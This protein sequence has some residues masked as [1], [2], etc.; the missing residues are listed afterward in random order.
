M[1]CRS[2]DRLDANTIKQNNKHAYLKPSKVVFRDN[3]W[4]PGVCGFTR[5]DS[6]FSVI[7]T[8][9]IFFFILSLIA[10]DRSRLWRCSDLFYCL[11]I[12]RMRPYRIMAI[13]CTV[14]SRSPS[15]PASGSSI[16]PPGCLLIT[17]HPAVGEAPPDLDVDIRP[18]CP[19]RGNPLPGL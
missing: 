14:R 4:H 13:L 11:I 16:R 19:Q 3:I 7:R 18:G 9:L 17:H 6:G 5:A 10:Y 8:R 15:A 2:L 1:C 12:T